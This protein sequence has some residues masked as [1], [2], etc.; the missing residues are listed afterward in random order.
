MKPFDYAIADHLEGATAALAR[1]YRSKGSGVDLLDLL[2]ERIE[3]GEKFVSLHKVESLRGI[4]EVNGML[5]IGAS[6]TLAEIAGN[7]AVQRLA[8]ALAHAAGEAA[9]PQIRARAT[10]A[11]NI[12]QRPRC[13]YYRAAEYDC[14]KKGGATC[15]AVEGENGYHALFGGGP[16]HI[17]HP[18]NIAPALVAHEATIVAVSP[19]GERKI[20][21]GEFF[22]LPER[23]LRGET[24]LLEN[25]IITEI[26]LPARESRSGF[27]ELRERQSFD[28]PVASCVARHDGNKWHIVL[29]HVAPIP[30][31]SKPAADVLG[32]SGSPDD[33]LASRA[34]D[35]AVKDAKPMSGN[36]W[37]IAIVRA[38]V[39]R[40]VLLA[41][42]KEIG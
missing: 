5:R 22:V 16:C 14:L 6:A 15:F 42:G 10:A 21:A 8:P 36:A 41:A 7:A 31:V 1:G 19:T 20:P 39:R 34:A 4:S 11:G 32:S 18:S 23:N 3:P 40:A 25:E 28:W 24:V 30:W 13:W 27:V 9:T 12:M 26:R 29:G 2:K 35:A 17:V 37:R 38:S 33:A